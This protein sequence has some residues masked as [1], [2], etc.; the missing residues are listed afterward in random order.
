MKNKKIN[1]KVS[2]KC[3]FDQELL[4]LLLGA[5]GGAI[6]GVPEKVSTAGHRRVLKVLENIG[7]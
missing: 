2:L 1:Q 4:V 3:S 5:D 7:T 6:T